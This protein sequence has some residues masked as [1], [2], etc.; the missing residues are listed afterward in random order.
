[1]DGF[2]SLGEC[3]YHLPVNLGNPTE[4]TILELAQKMIQVLNS[5]SKIVFRDL[6]EDD[7][8][9]RCPDVSLARELFGWEPQV[10]L[11]DGLRMTFEALEADGPRTN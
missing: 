8:A 9:V 4:H 6:P 11:A 3:D 1:M 5:N 2:L 7:P 10:D